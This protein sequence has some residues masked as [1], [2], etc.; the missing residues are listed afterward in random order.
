[1]AS[2]WQ[3]CEFLRQVQQNASLTG[4]PALPGTGELGKRKEGISFCWGSTGLGQSRWRA[5]GGGAPPA[6]PVPRAQ[7]RGRARP[8]HVPHVPVRLPQPRPEGREHESHRRLS[9]G[10]GWTVL[11]WEERACCRAVLTVFL[12]KAA[13][14]SVGVV[15]CRGSALWVCRGGP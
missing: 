10:K 14:F 13:P 9:P 5:L 7:L 15:C 12:L 6:P 4:G 11:F 3:R 1:M 8:S 2:S